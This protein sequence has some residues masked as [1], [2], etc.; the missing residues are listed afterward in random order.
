MKYPPETMRGD[1]PK[2]M[3]PIYQEKYIHM[4]NEITIP[5]AASIITAYVSEV[6]PLS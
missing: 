1:K 2:A 3:S 6:S 5:K 4:Q